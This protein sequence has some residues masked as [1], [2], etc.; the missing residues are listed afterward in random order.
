V[1]IAGSWVG[2]S[3][4]DSFSNGI[5]TSPAEQVADDDGSLI[6]ILFGLAQDAEHPIR[7][8]VV[9]YQATTPPHF[10]I[11]SPEI[12]ARYSAF[13]TPSCALHDG[14]IWGNISE[15]H[16]NTLS[17]MHANHKPASNLISTKL[18]SF[19]PIAARGLGLVGLIEAESLTTA[20]IA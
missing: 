5:H 6:S 12:Q 17:R 1:E 4:T 14:S 7:T 10:P 15:L 16:G 2:Q 3:E 20:G 18:Y 9:R 11:D 13:A 19:L 8:T